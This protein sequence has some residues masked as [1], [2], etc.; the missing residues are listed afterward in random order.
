MFRP[1]FRIRKMPYLPIKP[2]TSDQP[3]LWFYGK[4]PQIPQIQLFSTY[5]PFRN[6]IPNTTYEQIPEHLKIHMFTPELEIL[7]HDELRAPFKTFL[8]KF[9]LQ[10]LEHRSNEVRLESGNS[11]PAS[12]LNNGNVVRFM[13]LMSRLKQLFAI[14][15]DNTEVLDA[16]LHSQTALS[17]FEAKLAAKK[18]AREEKATLN[19]RKLNLGTKE[20]Y[21]QTPDSLE[22]RGFAGE[23]RI[24][25]DFE[26]KKNY[27]SISARELLNVLETRLERVHINDPEAPPHPGISKE[28]LAKFYGLFSRLKRI[29]A[30]N[31]GNTS[32]LDKLLD[33]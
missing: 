24:L 29:L 26:L 22:L 5:T 4:I 9:I 17:A 18:A 19:L 23:L 32:F 16:V 33:S 28:N 2:L 25:R 13:K 21:L 6:K 1:H 31:R 27:G 12:R 30:V 15:G 20:A 3:G 7:R 11:N 10:L 8:S 14:N